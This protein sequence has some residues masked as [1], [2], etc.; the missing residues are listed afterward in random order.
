MRYTRPAFGADV[1][2]IPA[3][4]AFFP[5]TDRLPKFDLPITPKENFYR[6]ARRDKPRWV[7]FPAA[8]LQEKHM[9]HLANH[10]PEGL[11]LGPVLSA[12]EARYEYMDSFG[13]HWTWDKNAGGACMTPGW[14]ST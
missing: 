3:L 6:A 8:D 1:P 9:C 14:R 5:N 7:P 2:T 13:N 4:N 12:K 10:G 11:Q